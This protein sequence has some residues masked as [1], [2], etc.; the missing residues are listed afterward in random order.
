MA[1]MASWGG[2]GGGGAEV[3]LYSGDFMH[4]VHASIQV[5]Q[6]AWYPLSGHV[7]S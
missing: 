4:T 6:R 7:P 3:A 5:G 1:F 2:G